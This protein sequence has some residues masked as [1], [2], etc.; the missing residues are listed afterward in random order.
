MYS[1]N[2]QP[3]KTS[4]PCTRE[5]IRNASSESH[6][7]RNGRGHWRWPKVVMEIRST[8]KADF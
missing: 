7:G 3:V 4:K 6:L 8:S 1:S 5:E 2:Y